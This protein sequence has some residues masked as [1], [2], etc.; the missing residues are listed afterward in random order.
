MQQHV[1]IA[2]GA[3]AI[4]LAVVLVFSRPSHTAQAPTQNGNTAIITNTGNVNGT[5]QQFVAFSTADIPERE[6]RFSFRT[7][8]PNTWRAEYLSDAHGMHFYRLLAVA[9]SSLDTTELFITAPT[10]AASPP[11]YLTVTGTRTV[12]TD[13]ITATIQTL[14]RDV[15]ALVDQ[16]VGYP[17]LLIADQTF[18]TV[19]PKAKTDTQSYL[20]V[21]A[22]T[23]SATTIDHILNSFAYLE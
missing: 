15:A 1:S 17:P 22:P 19:T 18:V 5:A 2:L 8:V 20:F 13:A 11:N 12:T 9:T 4:V 23:V 14:Q 10:K 21:F 3:V 6:Q 16:V 7:S